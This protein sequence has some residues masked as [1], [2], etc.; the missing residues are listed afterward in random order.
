MKKTI[1]T[2]ILVLAAAMCSATA[3]AQSSVDWKQELLSRITATGY[4]NV[5]WYYDNPNGEESNSFT[6]KRAPLWIQARITPR[7]SFRIMYNFANTKLQEL[8]TDYRVTNNGAL[9]V[10][11][12]QFKHPFTMEN[13]ISGKVVD[14]IDSYSLATQ[15]LAALGGDPLSGI[16]AGR[17]LGLM[18]FGDFANGVINYQLAVMNGQGINTKDGNNNKDLVAKLDIRPVKGLRFVA[19]GYLGKGHAT[20]AVAWNPDIAVG[21]NYT[22]DRYSVG[23]EYKTQSSTGFVRRE[24]RPISVR[25]EWMGGK[26]GKVGSRGGYLST[27]IPVAGGLDAVACAETYDYSTKV[28]GWDHSK[29]T[30][31][32]QYW[33]YKLCRVQVQYVRHFTGENI[34]SKD[35]NS[36]QAQLQVAF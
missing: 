15:H 3:V 5:G 28:D 10:R 11:L 12:G 7:W 19:T 30:A 6:V 29:L 31:G 2:L 33:F 8:Y 1:H 34:S 18:I 32:F 36:L 13:P 24:D 21:D 4:M 27:S 35:Y 16:S 20:S 17:D 22:R 25:A 23:V 9:S 14:Y 26:D